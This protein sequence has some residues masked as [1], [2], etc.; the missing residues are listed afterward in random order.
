MPSID[1]WTQ[2]RS[3]SVAIDDSIEEGTVKFYGYGHPAEISSSILLRYRER[4]SLLKCPEGIP[5]K[6][7][8]I[9]MNRLSSFNVVGLCLE[10]SVSGLEWKEIEQMELKC[11]QIS[12]SIVATATALELLSGDQASLIDEALRTK[13]ADR[14]YLNK[15]QLVKLE[16]FQHPAKISMP[17]EVWV[18]VRQLIGVSSFPQKFGR[19]D[20][21]S[22][23]VTIANNSVGSI[24]LPTKAQSTPI[25]NTQQRCLL[26]RAIKACFGQDE[27][28]L[29]K[30]LI[31]GPEGTGKM[32]VIKETAAA[33]G[34]VVHQPCSLTVQLFEEEITRLAS[35]HPTLIVVKSE[36]FVRAR[37][38]LEKQDSSGL[39][40]LLALHY[41]ASQKA[42]TDNQFDLVIQ[43]SVCF[44]FL[45][46]PLQMPCS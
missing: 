10:T 40:M 5:E 15:D 3:V 20:A 38:V 13:M 12:F 6:V 36:D 7:E 34:L 27:Q 19:F 26:E 9:K 11:S 35:F 41:S 28:T 42:P 14:M 32:T 17:L 29:F 18:K 33:L 1:E 43:F 23:K 37:M 39:V 25:F 22:T 24:I 16:I 46:S 30:F 8:S 2:L 4:E 21:D 31:S 44:P 45:H